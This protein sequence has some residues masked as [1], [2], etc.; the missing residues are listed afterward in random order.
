MFHNTNLE[1]AENLKVQNNFAVIL[2]F[3]GKKMT[4]VWR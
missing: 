4:S 1:N 3:E 2:H